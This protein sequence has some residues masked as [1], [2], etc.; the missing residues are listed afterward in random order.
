MISDQ[1]ELRQAL[2]SYGKGKERLNV[3]ALL[4]V[5]G[6]TEDSHAGRELVGREFGFAP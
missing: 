4:R 3:E 1:D 2:E 5:V 6:S